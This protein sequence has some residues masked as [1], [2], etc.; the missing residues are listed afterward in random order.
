MLMPAVAVVA[1]FVTLWFAMSTNNAMVVD[2]YYRE[3]KAINQELARDREAAKRGLR[4]TLGQMTDGGIELQIAT[5]N[6]SLPPFVTLRIVHATRA[7]LDRT[8]TLASVSPGT[9]R[10][11]EGALPDAGRWNVL[12]E[13]PDHK[14]RLTAEG[15]GFAEPLR[16]GETR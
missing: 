13:E 15:V 7:E 4:A 11:Q 6:G 16:F 9:Y 10:V 5:L 8:F 1:G 12:I 3:G 2:D 14:W